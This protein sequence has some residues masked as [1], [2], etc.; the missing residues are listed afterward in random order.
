ME[1]YSFK[2]NFL[3]LPVEIQYQIISY[4]KGIKTIRNL[5]E[6]NKYI[7]NLL[8]YCIRD[9]YIPCNIYIKP[10]I[11]LDLPKFGSNPRGGLGNIA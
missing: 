7:Q 8:R 4:I 3:E 1:E 5:W 2:F 10:Y 9:L 11:V 6:T